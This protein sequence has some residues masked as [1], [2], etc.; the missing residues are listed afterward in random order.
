MEPLSDRHTGSPLGGQQN[1]HSHPVENGNTDSFEFVPMSRGGA[2]SGMDARSFSL[3][4]SWTAQDS[5]LE[6]TLGWLLQSSHDA[7]GS[8]PASVRTVTSERPVKA[9]SV[10]LS[11]TLSQISHHS[12]MTDRSLSLPDTGLYPNYNT[13]NLYSESK[14]IDEI[15]STHGSYHNGDAKGSSRR[16]SHMM[17][18]VTGS[19]YP[20]FTSPDEVMFTSPMDPMSQA[21]FEPSV[22]HDSISPAMNPMDMNDSPWPQWEREESE[23]STPYSSDINWPAGAATK[24]TISYPSNHA[25][26]S[27]RYVVIQSVDSHLPHTFY[28]LGP[29]GRPWSS[30]T[31]VSMEITL[32]ITRRDMM[33]CLDLTEAIAMG[34]LTMTVLPV[35]I[36]CTRRPL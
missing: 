29:A 4:T 8:P 27:P 1:F 20:A 14:Y 9:Q 32:P 28:L 11:Q 33:A 18:I 21:M 26:N 30:R 25:T 17:P 34:A 31:A 12:G 5:S 24:H 36:R 2:V 22:T 15:D 6:T 10:E 3:D 35:S 16:Q 13:D 7:M 19:S 23:G